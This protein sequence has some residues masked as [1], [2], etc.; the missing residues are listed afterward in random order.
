MLCIIFHD[1]SCVKQPCLCDFDLG[2]YLEVKFI[3]QQNQNLIFGPNAIFQID[4]IQALYQ[5]DIF[6]TNTASVK[7]GRIDLTNVEFDF[8]R[9]EE[10]TLYINQQ[11]TQDSLEIKWVTKTGK[12][13][14]SNQEYNAVDSSKI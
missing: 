8:Y 7:K 4:S 9:P 14:E 2:Q 5:K 3:N 11:T 10:K 6:N 12:C 13:C 1:V